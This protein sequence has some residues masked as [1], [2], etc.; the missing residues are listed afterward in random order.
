MGKDPDAYRT[1]SEVAAAL[2]I[3]PHVLRFWETKFTQIKPLKRGGGRRFYRR[4]DVDLLRAVRRLLYDDAYTI[5][6]VQ[7]L[8]KSKGI[9]AVVALEPGEAP[10]DGADLAGPDLPPLSELAAAGPN[11]ALV[12]RFASEIAACQAILSEALR[13]AGDEPTRP[14]PAEAVDPAAPVSAVPPP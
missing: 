12:A 3:P 5:R 7:R 1:I 13:T 2:D 14:P 6:G 10:P 11:R 4:G 9:A 8:L